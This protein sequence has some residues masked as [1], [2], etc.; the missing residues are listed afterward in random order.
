MARPMDQQK[1]AVLLAEVVDYIGTHGLDNLT[2]RPLAAALGTSSRMLIYYFESRENLIVQALASQRPAFSEMFGDV[3]DASGL[4]TRL[5]EL[6]TSMTVG[7]DVVSSR[8]L[9]QVIGIGS[10]NSGVLGDFAAATVHSLTDALAESLRRCGFDDALE[11]AT[12]LG[13]AFRGLLVDRFATGD[14]H[15]TDAAAAAL[16]ESVAAR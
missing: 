5:S 10:I 15:R 8:I 4:R 1:R 9:M 11:R 6:W 16:F 3:H 14:V 2:L 7:D 13:A 12:V